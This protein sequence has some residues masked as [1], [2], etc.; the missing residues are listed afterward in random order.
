LYLLIAMGNDR[1]KK[2]MLKNKIN[3]NHDDSNDAAADP[4][5]TVKDLLFKPVS[6]MNE[7]RNYLRANN[8]FHAK[9]NP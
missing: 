4:N 2:E 7:S 5:S 9:N 3:L 6:I 1:W 8:K